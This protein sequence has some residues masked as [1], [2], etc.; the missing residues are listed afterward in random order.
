M[1]VDEFSVPAHVAKKLKE[2]GYA[3]DTSMDTNIQSWYGWYSGR[4]DW[5][6]DGYRDLQGRHRARM[7]M[8]IR[9]AKRVA[10]EWASLL[11]PTTRR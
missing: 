10:M 6:R 7:R 5:Y 2:L 9:P 8:S 4:D 11:V 3:V 1:A